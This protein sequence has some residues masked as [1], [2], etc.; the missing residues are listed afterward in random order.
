MPLRMFATDMA[1]QR[2]CCE[3]ALSGGLREPHAGVGV[4][5]VP[6]RVLR[7][8]LLVVVLGVVVGDVRGGTDLGGDVAD[9]LPVQLVAVDLGQLPG[10]L[11]LLG[12]RPVDG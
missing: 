12:G 9:P 6:E 3:P 8:V 7:K 11:L 4:A 2:N 5:P 10:G 1:P